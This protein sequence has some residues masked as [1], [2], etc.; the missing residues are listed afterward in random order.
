MED[1][2][3]VMDGIV[4]KYVCDDGGIYRGQCPQ[5]IKWL[6]LIMGG[7]WNG[8]TGNGNEVLGT[9]C[10]NFDGYWGKPKYDYRLCSA[11]NKYDKNGH[12]WIEVKIDGKW[13]RYEQNVNNAGANSA[14]FGCGKV[15]SVTKTDKALPSY[16][17]NI[18]YAG[19][20]S[21]DYYIKVYNEKPKPQPEPTPSE[22][23]PDWF[24][25]WANN[26]AEYIKSI[27]K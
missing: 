3:K 1:F 4:G 16:L 25:K 24:K 26:L 18:K 20:P 7:Y 14:D 27:T 6:V 23:M 17:Y 15:Y 13:W 11:D 19:H 8:R 12:C 2:I 5:L 22:E 21:V 10:D 9:M